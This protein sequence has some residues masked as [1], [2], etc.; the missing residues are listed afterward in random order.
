MALATAVL[1]A[2]PAYLLWSSLGQRA[3]TARY[4]GIALAILAAFAGAYGTLLSA[5][6][7]PHAGL[8]WTALLLLSWPVLLVLIGGALAP[9][10]LNRVR[11]T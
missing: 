6:G 1:V 3:L 4:A 5:A 11:H 10:A 7:E 8:H 9:W 2:V